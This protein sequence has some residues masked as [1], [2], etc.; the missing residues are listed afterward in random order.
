MS[1]VDKIVIIFCASIFNISLIGC[2]ERP[3]DAVFEV[4]KT[5]RFEPDLTGL[6]AFPMFRAY[7][8]ADSAR[9][10]AA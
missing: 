1:E 2:I 7:A 8:E 3:A 4:S 10:S 5:H 9:T 6:T